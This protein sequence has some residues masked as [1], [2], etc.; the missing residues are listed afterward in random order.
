MRVLISIGLLLALLTGCGGGAVIYA[1]TPAPADTSPTVY[2]HP[3]GSFSLTIPRLWP[4]HVQH[5][6]ALATA[7][8]SPP[9]APEPLLTVA[10]INLGAPVDG[11]GFAALLDQY[12]VAIRPDAG[13]YV[14]SDR[15]A[16]GDGS[17]RLTGLRQGPGDA[18]RQI[19]TF[20]ERRDS[21][22]AVLEVVLSGDAATDAAL[23]NAINS[24]RISPEADLL[25]ADVTVLAAVASAELEALHITPWTTPN[26]VFFIT[27]EVVNQGGAAAADV[28]VRAILRSPDGLALAEADDAPM[29]YY[30]PPGGFAPFSLRFAG[31]PTGAD[32][33]ELIVTRAD[34]PAAIAPGPALSWIDESRFDEAGRLIIEGTVTNTGADPAAAPRALVTVFDADGGVIGAAFADLPFD[35]LAPNASAP[36]NITLAELGGEPAQYLVNIQAR[37]N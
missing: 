8:F 29:G 20:V 10:L 19:N 13:R 11:A 33:Y 7:A 12:Q 23:Q 15:G 32:R 22:L 21:Y 36:F 17:W 26:G 27:G 25:P 35:R 37:P 6:T 24:F 1:P 31:Q 30:I 4:V 34:A 9:G 2:T 18:T 16:M 5:T 3:G 14:E 28:R